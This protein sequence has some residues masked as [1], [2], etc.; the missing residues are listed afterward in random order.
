M[1][2]GSDVRA[3]CAAVDAETG[4]DVGTP[5]VDQRRGSFFNRVT[6]SSAAQWLFAV[7]D[8]WHVHGLAIRPA[9]RA[10]AP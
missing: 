3:P 2:I 6:A 7:A 5:N 1:D 9:R 8:R 4:S 10:P